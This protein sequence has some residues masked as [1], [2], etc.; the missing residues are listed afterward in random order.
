MKIYL[1]GI[2][3][4]IGYSFAM[5]PNKF[6]MQK[7][8]KLSTSKKCPGTLNTSCVKYQAV[9]LKG[10]HPYQSLNQNCVKFS[11]PG[12]PSS[13]VTVHNVYCPREVRKSEK[14]DRLD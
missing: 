1:L 11:K 5:E 4:F 7:T 2:L 6:C 14:K 10:M 9:C 8:P 13:L 3:G 12:Y